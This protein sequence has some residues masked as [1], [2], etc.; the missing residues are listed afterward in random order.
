MFKSG[1]V[2]VIGRPNSGK[3]TLINALVGKKVTITSHHPNTTRNAIRAI[4]HTDSYQAV[5]VDT[6]GIHKPQTTL[7]NQLNAIARD[8]TD[9]V[10]IVLFTI[11]ANEKVGKGDNFVARSIAESSS[12]RRF[13]IVTKIDTVSKDRILTALAEAAKLAQD[14][15]FTWDE[16]IPVSAIK[17]EQVWI[18]ADLIERNLPEGPAYY[19]KETLVDLEIGEQISELIRE[20]TI[21]GTLQELPHSIAVVVNEVTER[22]DQLTAIDAT[23]FVERDSQKGIIVGRAGENIKA[24]GSAVRPALETL[25]GKKIHLGL[26]VSVASNW[27]GDAKA[28]KKFGIVKD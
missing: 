17:G 8:S 1:F 22:S 27:Q 15:G 2:A 6:P 14:N 5:L 3:S 21:A 18:L 26:N 28:L 23:I 24:I 13:C 20:A 9:S 16:I 10:D 4:L 25:M 7:G 12:A 11:A 19:P